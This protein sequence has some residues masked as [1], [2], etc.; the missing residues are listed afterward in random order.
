MLGCAARRDHVATLRSRIRFTITTKPFWKYRFLCNSCATDTVVQKWGE[1]SREFDSKQIPHL[2]PHWNLEKKKIFHLIRQVYGQ[3]F[4]D[5]MRYWI[6]H[7]YEYFFFCKRTDEGVL[8]ISEAFPHEATIPSVLQCIKTLLGFSD[9]E[10]RL[11]SR[12][13]TGSTND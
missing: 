10:L 9:H 8:K 7:I 3:M 1:A 4:A 5:H 12:K 2:P 11:C 13:N 6:F